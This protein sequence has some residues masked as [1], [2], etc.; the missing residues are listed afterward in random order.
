MRR[1]KLQTR[2]IR[3]SAKRYTKSMARKGRQRA[4]EEDFSNAW[5]WGSILKTSIF[6]NYLGKSLVID[7]SW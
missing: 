7:P 2:E 5:Y 1:T 6:G 3:V 4:D